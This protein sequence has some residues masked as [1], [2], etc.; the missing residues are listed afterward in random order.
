MLRQ[1][2]CRVACCLLLAALA[3][4][5][6]FS[7]VV[8]N[9]KVTSHG[10]TAQAPESIQMFAEGE[11]IKMGMSAGE[12]GTEGE[13]IFSRD[14]SEMM[15]VDHSSNG[16]F[17]MNEEAVGQIAEQINQAMAQMQEMLKDMPAEQ[18][19]MAEKM[20]QQQ[21]SGAATQEEQPESELKK[22]NEK[23]TH[24]GYP[25]VKY[26]LWRDGALLHELWVTEWKNIKGG[27]QIAE[28]F[29]SMAL[30]FNKLM[31]AIP[32]MGG[33]EALDV[34]DNLFSQ[35][36][37]FNG[38]PVVSR[39]FVDGKLNNETMLESVTEQDMDPDAFE[40]P[41]GYALRSMGQM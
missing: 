16:Y 8:F 15:I 21:M 24:S 17:V 19:E 5:P 20:M 34:D 31:E 10:E 33:S 3:F 40:P 7:A 32:S 25:C 2:S 35:M 13:V 30:F 4:A 36:H 41:E 28:T 12:V 23:A 14:R 11:F 18:R 38:F 26:E 6:A 29:E 39:S 22:T 1:P 9:I 27:A 37:Q